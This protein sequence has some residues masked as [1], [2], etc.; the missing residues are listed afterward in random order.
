MTEKSNNLSTE[1]QYTQEQLKEMYEKSFNMYDLDLF[2]KD[3]KEDTRVIDGRVVRITDKDVIIDVG[4]KSEGI[5]PLSEFS[6]PENIKI[7]EIVPI[8]IEGFENEEGFA[9]ISLKKAQFIKLWPKIND[10]FENKTNIEGIIRKRVKGGMIVDLLGVEAFLPGS[11]IDLQP[12]VD[13][14]KLLNVKTDFRVIKLNYKRRNIVVSRRV[15]LENEKESKKFE[16]IK[17]LKQGDVVEGIVKNITEFGAFIEI[18]KGIDGLLYITDMSW[19]RIV[20]PSEIL[21]INEK[22]KVMITTINKEKGRI[23]LGLKQLTPYPWENIEAKF[24]IG[25]RV[26]GRV[27]SLEEYGAFVELEKGVEGLIHISEMS[28]TQHLKHPSEILNMGDEI[29]SIVLSIDKRNERISLGLKQISDNPWDKFTVGERVKG[30]ITKLIKFG[31][32][33]EIAP[34]IEGLLHISNISWDTKIS[35]IE[36]I[37]K[38]GDEIDCLIVN[39]NPEKK[40]I[41]LGIKQLQ[42]DPIDDYKEGDIIKGIIFEVKDKNVHVEVKEKIKGLIPQRLI[43]KQSENLSDDY[44]KGNEIELKVVD[45]DKE[46]RRIIFSDKVE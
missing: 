27:V 45:I 34:G 43:A 9:D 20:H 33:V 19:G 46:R 17:N 36:D 1:N 24:Q 40:R 10:S 7:G 26:K 5:I 21:T 30:S 13:M 14:D 2:A 39:I 4:L 11:Q 32:F 35:K 22:I 37:Y 28:W 18:E 38:V 6:E 8:F 15:I 41:S 12:V 42:K 25:M 3:E 44:V 29:E 23:S 31:A 16:F